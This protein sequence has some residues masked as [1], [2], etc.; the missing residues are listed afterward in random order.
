MSKYK[1]NIKPASREP[2][3]QHEILPFDDVISV[4]KMP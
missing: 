3:E 1:M 4:M 2:C